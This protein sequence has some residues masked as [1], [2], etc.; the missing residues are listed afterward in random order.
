MGAPI[1][2]PRCD[3]QVLGGAGSETVVLG[4]MDGAFGAGFAALGAEEATAKIHMGAPG[5]E[6]DGLGGA[7]VGAGA[8][9][10]RTLLCLD[11][12]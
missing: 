7:G 3:D 10:L 11:L 4:V 1:V 5:I 8:T 9:T 6:L 12:G 2:F